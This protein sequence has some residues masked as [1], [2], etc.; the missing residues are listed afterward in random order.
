MAVSDARDRLVVA[1]LN[2]G[3]LQVFR[4]GTTAGG[5]AVRPLV[6]E[7][8]AFGAAAEALL[9]GRLDAVSWF[10][11]GSYIP[12]MVFVGDPTIEGGGSVEAGRDRAP[13]LSRLG[14]AR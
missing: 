8:L 9:S 11:E 7:R 14:P 4:L 13:S 2:S 3:S 1:S 5:S 6:P 10:P 12:A